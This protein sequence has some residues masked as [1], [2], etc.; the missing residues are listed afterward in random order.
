MKTNLKFAGIFLILFTV[1]TGVNAQVKEST[2][3]TPPSD[4]P[5]GY[6][7]DYQKTIEIIIER[8]ISPD[9]SNQDIQPIL[10][11]KDFPA[12]KSGQ[13]PDSKYK[14]ILGNWIIANQAIIINTLKHRKNIV[15]Q[16]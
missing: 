6:T 8:Q 1:S 3:V 5:S 7:F 13:T 16:Y 12:L 4:A 9:K 15:T 2:K 10:N 11:Q 14:E